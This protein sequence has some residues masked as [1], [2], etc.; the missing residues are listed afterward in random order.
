[1]PR[2]ASPTLARAMGIA[3]TYKTLCFLPLSLEDLDLRHSFLCPNVNLPPTP[4]DKYLYPCWNRKRTHM[5]SW[6][7]V[8][9]GNLQGGIDDCLAHQ[10]TNGGST[11]WEIWQRDCRSWYFVERGIGSCFAVSWWLAALEFACMNS[12]SFNCTSKEAVAQELSLCYGSGGRGHLKWVV[13]SW[14]SC[15]LSARGYIVLRQT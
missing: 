5:S 7:N 2:M 10:Y 6:K 14:V 12:I 13:D 15:F 8:D 9:E 11:V 1:M 3:G 4:E